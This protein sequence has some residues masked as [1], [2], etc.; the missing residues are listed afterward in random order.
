MLVFSPQVILKFPE[1]FFHLFSMNRLDNHNAP[2]LTLSHT[3]T[4]YFDILQS[5]V[6]VYDYALHQVL[7]VMAV[8]ISAII[9]VRRFS[10]KLLLAQLAGIV[11]SITF[12]MGV[13]YGLGVARYS[14]N[15]FSLPILTAGLFLAVS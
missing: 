3:P 1:M 4:V 15:W 8:V 9:I 10:I 11:L 7:S 5:Y 6:V 14:L 12:P 13:G 2:S